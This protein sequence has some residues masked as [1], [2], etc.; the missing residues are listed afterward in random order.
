MKYSNR[1]I[2]NILN[3]NVYRKHDMK[4]QYKF[5]EL[6]ILNH[7]TE[8]LYNS[9]MEYNN[10]V[11]RFQ[12]TLSYQL[13]LPD[14]LPD[15]IQ[16]V[17]TDMHTMKCWCSFT[18]Q[19]RIFDVNLH[20]DGT[21]KYMQ[22][23][24][25]EH[26]K[27]IYMW[28]YIAS[29]YASP[30]CSKYVKI[31]IYL[32]PHKKKLPKQYNIVDREHANTA[33]TTSCQTETEICIFR[34]EEWLKTFIH[35]TFHSMGMDFSA[36]GS[37][38]TNELIYTFIPIETDV[39]LYE[40]YTEC[41]AEII[42][43]LFV[44]FY[45]M[46]KRGSTNMENVFNIVLNIERRFSMFQCA[47]VLNHYNMRF[48]DLFKQTKLASVRR[49]NYKENTPILSYYLLKMVLMYNAKDFIVWTSKNNDR[50]INFNRKPDPKKETRLVN[51]IKKRMNM[52]IMMEMLDKA[53]KYLKE[54][55]NKKNMITQSLRMTV[56]EAV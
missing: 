13:R 9:E 27:K 17:I 19:D 16:N 55:Q 23:D 30:K 52:P 40:A 14:Y 46:K 22:H 51:F 45:H 37:Q 39:R 7:I 29:R 38:H 6:P 2:L 47:K 48:D 25:D 1:H 10:L 33:F 15:T 31:N 12:S 53:N 20:F 36:N 50:T 11:N 4:E 34:E 32:T 8:L 43:S 24:I 26:F 28:L 44:A 56:Y 54:S 3:E 49:N 42:N 35:E 41:W 18:I 21:K 5:S